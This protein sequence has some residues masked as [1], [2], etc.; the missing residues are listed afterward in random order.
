MRDILNNLDNLVASFMEPVKDYIMYGLEYLM[1]FLK[2]QSG[3]LFTLVFVIL[4]FAIICILGLFKFMR[5]A[6]GLFLLLA[7]I[8][9]LLIAM[10]IIFG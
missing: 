5:K 4:F 9:G 6:L 2:E 3:V 1:S 8:C 7:I 10:C